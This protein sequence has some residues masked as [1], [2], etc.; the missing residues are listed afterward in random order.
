M[1][2]ALARAVLIIVAV[3]ATMAACHAWDNRNLDD[4]F[5]HEYTP[6]WWLLVAVFTGLLIF[7]TRKR[8]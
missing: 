7:V 2:S 5:W 3:L 4:R 8:K 6:A 1:P